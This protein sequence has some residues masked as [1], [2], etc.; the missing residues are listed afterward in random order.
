MTCL[1][2]IPNHKL[3]IIIAI[4]FSFSILRL[5]DSPPPT[6]TESKGTLFK[7][8]WC[9]NPIHP[10][11]VFSLL[12]PELPPAFD[13][14]TC[15]KS[16]ASSVSRLTP[17]G[18][19]VGATSFAVMLVKLA[20]R[21]RRINRLHLLGALYPNLVAGPGSCGLLYHLDFRTCSCCLTVHKF[22]PLGDW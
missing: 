3:L 19:F 9:H 5:P 6:P 4:R 16:W 15:G 2:S 14:Q 7:R 1:S 8:T 10:T 20:Q 21:Q 17:L 11:A 22:E 12:H 18:G 13:R